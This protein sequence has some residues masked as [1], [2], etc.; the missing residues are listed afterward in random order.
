MERLLKG[1]MSRAGL[2][3]MLFSLQADT[4]AY[5]GRLA[6]AGEFTKEASASATSDG[7]SELATGYQIMEA[8][9]EAEFGYP[10]RTRQQ[11]DAALAHHPA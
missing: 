11:V 3:D 10:D 2:E 6:S 4:E 7:D 8:L 5:Y 9:H 1:A